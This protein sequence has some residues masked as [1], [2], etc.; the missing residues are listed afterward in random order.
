MKLNQEYLKKLILNIEEVHAPRPTLKQ[1]LQSLNLSDLNDEFLLHYEV[2]RDYGFIEGVEDPANIGLVNTDDGV[3][4]IDAHIRLTAKGHEF[5]TALNTPEIWT[6]LKE[7]FKEDS[8]DT[9]FNVS[10]E[11]VVKFAK[12]KIEEIL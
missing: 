3:L 8:V 11:L 10:K 4:W 6:V 7:K 12:K 5:A 1:I 2:L 9:L